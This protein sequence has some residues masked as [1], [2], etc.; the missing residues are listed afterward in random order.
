LAGRWKGL[1]EGKERKEILTLKL[2]FNKNFK[3]FLNRKSY[4]LQMFDIFISKLIGIGF[5]LDAKFRQTA[6]FRAD[7]RARELRKWI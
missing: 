3:K 4:I 6:H 7:L 5:N 2:Y 1:E